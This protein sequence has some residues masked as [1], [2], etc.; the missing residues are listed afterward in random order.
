MAGEILG[1]EYHA[2]LAPVRAVVAG[3]VD[4]EGNRP[5]YPARLPPQ[6]RPI[7][8]G[9]I[10]V[11]VALATYPA[12]A[13]GVGSLLTPCK[14]LGPGWVAVLVLTAYCKRPR[15]PPHPPGGILKSPLADATRP[16]LM[17]RE[18]RT[19][20]VEPGTRNASVPSKRYPVA[21]RKCRD[22]DSNCCE[23]RPRRDPW[24]SWSRQHTVHGNCTGR[25]GSPS[26]YR[27]DNRPEAERDVNKYRL[28]PA[29]RH[30]DCRN[31]AI[32]RDMEH[33]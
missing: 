17:K 25:T 19:N 28:V 14:H 8:V 4:R 10:Y 15:Y 13:A 31:W 5:E 33:Y 9:I 11:H 29:N 16:D 12:L 1:H 6:F 7:H 26:R 18:L 27:E 22:S 32:G 24:G 23:G 30:L 2:T 3:R 21:L 20:G